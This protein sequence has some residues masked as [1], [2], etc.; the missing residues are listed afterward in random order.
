MFIAKHEHVRVGGPQ[1]HSFGLL[2]T[3][4]EF[5]SWL[6]QNERPAG[7]AGLDVVRK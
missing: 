7:G 4:S 2:R 1:N 6:T 5:V 3:Q